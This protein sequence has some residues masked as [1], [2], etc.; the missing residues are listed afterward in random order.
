MVEVMPR[1]LEDRGGGLARVDGRARVW[2]K[3]LAM[4]REEDEFALTYYN[5][6]TTWIEID[7]AISPPSPSRG[8]R[9]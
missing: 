1:R 5:S 3:G 2:W 6:L 8:P 7:R 4:P 9:I